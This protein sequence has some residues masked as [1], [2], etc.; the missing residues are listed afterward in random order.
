V[1]R[2]ATAAVTEHSGDV[3]ILKRLDLCRVFLRQIRAPHDLA[4]SETDPYSA[5]MKKLMAYLE[6]LIAEG[7]FGTVTLSFQSGKLCNIK[8]ERSL[9]P[10]EL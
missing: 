4:L 9:K 10:T 1:T 7:F 3:V 2:M 8:G 5:R 6:K